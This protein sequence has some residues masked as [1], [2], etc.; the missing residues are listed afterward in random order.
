[1][2]CYLQFEP[3]KSQMKTSNLFLSLLILTLISSSCSSDNNSNNDD[4]PS[5]VLKPSSFTVTESDGDNWTLNF[6]YNENLISKI[7]T[8]YGST[9]TYNYD[10]KRLISFTTTQ[11]GT[12]ETTQFIYENNRLVETRTD[13]ELDIYKFFYNSSGQINKVNWIAAGND[14]ISFLEYDNRGNVIEEI[15][16]FSTFRFTYDNKNNPFKNVFPQ[17]DAE[18]WWPWYGS[19]INNQLEVSEKL[20]NESTFSTKYTYEY[21]FNE[22]NFPIQRRQVRNDGSI[23]E[24]VNYTY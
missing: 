1:V 8:D 3:K 6:E 22:N 2:A 15:D 16:D 21:D 18:I 23:G 10:G 5:S 17:L 4:D 9:T 20:A 13:D 12:S 19:L 7:T 14:N 24:T 11:N